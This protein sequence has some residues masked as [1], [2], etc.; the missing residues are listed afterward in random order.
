MKGAYGYS[1]LTSFSEH[2]QGQ[3]LWLDWPF[4]MIQP[5]WSS[6]DVSVPSSCME[7]S[8]ASPSVESA[9]D[10]RCEGLRLPSARHGILGRSQHR[11]WVGHAIRCSAGQGIHSYANHAIGCSVIIIDSPL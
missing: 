11:S 8:L 5:S 6:G 9:C 3:P 7:S 1:S 2:L 10:L 4:I